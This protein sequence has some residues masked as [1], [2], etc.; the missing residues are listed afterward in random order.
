MATANKRELPN[1]IK[2]KSPKRLRFLMLQNNL[3]LRSTIQY[4]DIQFVKGEWYAWYFE[5]RNLSDL[6]KDLTDGTASDN[7]R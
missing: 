4:F 5:P 7:R 2:A 6:E 3:R 1:F